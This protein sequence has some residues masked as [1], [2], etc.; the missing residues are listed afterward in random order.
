MILSMVYVNLQQELVIHLFV[1]F[2]SQ[3]NYPDD[4]SPLVDYVYY[5]IEKQASRDD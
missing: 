3:H 2:Y 5:F 4:S 1:I